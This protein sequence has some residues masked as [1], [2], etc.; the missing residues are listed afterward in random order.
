MGDCNLYIFRDQVIQHEL[1]FTPLQ[2]MKL[3]TN[4]YTMIRL[5]CLLNPEY[6]EEIWRWNYADKIKLLNQFRDVVKELKYSKLD[7]YYQYNFFHH[8]NY[9]LVNKDRIT[10]FGLQFD[11]KQVKHR[12]HILDYVSSS[13][14]RIGKLKYGFQI[15]TYMLD[16]ELP[17]LPTF[18]FN[19]YETGAY[20]HTV[21]ELESYLSIMK[22]NG[23]KGDLLHRCIAFWKSCNQSYEKWCSNQQCFYQPLLDGDM[24]QSI[25]LGKLAGK[26]I[27][28]IHSHS[29]YEPIPS[30]EVGFIEYIDS[31]RILK[32]NWN[33][34]TYR[35]IHCGDDQF[36]LYF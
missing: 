4:D 36:I 5:M 3:L 2:R 17:H 8:T 33:N 21:E 22:Y 31:S 18:V 25:L 26:S 6:Q 11:V 27:Q 34:G 24:Y 35:N 14:Q 16:W 28:L 10:D 13:H 7:D 30:G 12:D 23:L 20:L 9:F 19:D 15:A 29:S 32:I 1:Q